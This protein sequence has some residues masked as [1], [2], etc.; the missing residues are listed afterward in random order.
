MKCSVEDCEKKS[1]ARGWCPMHYRRWRLHGDPNIVVRGPEGQAWNFRGPYE[2]CWEWSGGVFNEGRKGLCYGRVW[3]KGRNRTVHRLVWEEFYGEIPEGLEVCHT[4][5]NPKCWRPD[6]LFLG[7]HKEN[8]EDRKLKGRNNSKRSATGFRLPQTR[9][10]DKDVS[11]IRSL[12]EARKHTQKELSIIFGVT[13]SHI[14]DIINKR[15]RVLLDNSLEGPPNRRLVWNKDKG[16]CG[17]C[18]APADVDDWDLDH[19]IPVA[20]GGTDTF[21][22]V[23]VS[24]PLCNKKKSNN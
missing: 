2:G 16:I 1:W 7:T 14:S 19:I 5:D 8:M 18:N 10:S 23:Q 20:R 21:D 13:Q 22:N 6:H 17:I 24:H 12:Y 11:E 3:F 4:C 15:R 9:L